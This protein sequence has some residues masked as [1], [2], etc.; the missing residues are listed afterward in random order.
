M[1]I[2]AVALA[3]ALVFAMSAA[4]VFCAVKAALL[5]EHEA[6][7]PWT[8]LLREGFARGARDFGMDA[9]VVVLPPGPE[10][11]RGFQEAA[12]R[13][14]LVILASDG[15]HEALRDNAANFRRVNFGSVDA[16]IRAPNI[17]SVT[18]ADEQA[19]F[20]AGAAAAMAASAMAGKGE[21]AIGW[22]SGEDTP[23]MRSLH[24]GFAEGARLA[25]PDVRVLQAVAGSFTDRK[26]GAE[27]AAWLLQNGARV[28]ALAAGAANP[29]PELLQGARFISL[30]KP[31]AGALAAISKKA[32]KA[33]YEIMASM[34]SGK[35]RGKEI[36]VYDLKN[37]G[38][39]LTALGKEAGPDIGRRVGELRRELAAG[40]IR[41]KS[42]RARTLC[43]CLD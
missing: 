24:N 43:D 26:A 10:Q 14:D 42:L 16:G 27:K 38:T 29:A 28:I 2:F 17:M 21:A 33:V 36:V 7:S 41:V 30:D 40:S 4:P 13:S 18:F 19:A 22:L 31:A 5:L 32:D 23:A 20:L 6:P 15:L 34:A 25:N 3:A 35:F 39:D 1:R 8:D 37:G 12:A 9:E 11:R